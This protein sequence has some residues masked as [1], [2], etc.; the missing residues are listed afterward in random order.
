[1]KW[2]VLSLISVILLTSLLA[3]CGGEPVNANLQ[4]QIDSQSVTISALQSDI[5]DRDSTIASLQSLLAQK[6]ARIGELQEQIIDLEMSIPEEPE[7]PLWEI[8]D[9]SARVT[10]KNNTWWKN[11]W[12]LVLQNNSNQ[13]MTFNATI[14]FLDSDGFVI[15]DDLAYG[16]VVPA[17]SQET[18]TGYGLIV[19][20]VA[21]N[22]ATVNAKVKLR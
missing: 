6:D 16:L 9:I 15:D 8:A 19:T 22:V 14:E 21:P 4:E 5:S 18:F 20:D 17:S 7:G 3:G 10:E 2:F 1:L 12:I 11:A 13:S